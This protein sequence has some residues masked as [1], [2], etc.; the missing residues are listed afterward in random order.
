MTGGAFGENAI[1]ST[2]VLAKLDDE[3]ILIGGYYDEDK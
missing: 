2:R 3:Q 1:V